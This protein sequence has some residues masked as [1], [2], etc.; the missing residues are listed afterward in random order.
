MPTTLTKASPISSLCENCYFLI[1]TFAHVDTGEQQEQPVALRCAAIPELNLGTEQAL[2][3]A[4]PDDEGNVNAVVTFITNCSQFTPGAKLKIT[5]LTYDAGV[6]ELVATVELSNLN[7]TPDLD[8]Y[9]VGDQTSLHT[10][11]AVTSATV[12]VTIPLSAP[13]ADGSYQLYMQLS[14][15]EKSFIYPFTLT[16]S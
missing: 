14:T 6:P 9:F 5:A 10:E 8:F 3:D 1:K 15:N 4:T 11:A 2:N 12:S 16:T 13:L 7:G